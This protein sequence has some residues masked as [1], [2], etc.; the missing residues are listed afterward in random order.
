MMAIKA[1]NNGHDNVLEFL[2][3]SCMLDLKTAINQ[4]TFVDAAERGR[5]NIVQRLLR[6]NVDPNE[7]DIS[8][9]TPL[10]MAAS[11]G[12]IA[13]AEL[14]LQWGAHSEY[15]CVCVV[16]SFAFSHSVPNT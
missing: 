1:V 11:R 14:L 3:R 16:V 6:A 13:V 9:S 8:G 4:G 7:H 12:K 15:V 5:Y 10:S 2:Q